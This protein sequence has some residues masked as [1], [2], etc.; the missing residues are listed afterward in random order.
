MSIL[1]L[2]SRVWWLSSST[3]I[4][5]LDNVKWSYKESWYDCRKGLAQKS[6][7][8]HT[9]CCSTSNDV[10]LCSRL[11]CLL[12]HQMCGCWKCCSKRLDLLT[13]PWVWRIK[14]KEECQW[15]CYVL[16]NQKEEKKSMN[17]LLDDRTKWKTW[18]KRNKR[19]LFSLFFIE[20]FIAAIELDPFGADRYVYCLYSFIMTKFYRNQDAIE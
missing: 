19:T 20:S 11:L 1:N 6:K 3:E 13:F 15:I 18:K 14:R 8:F 2:H 17:M 10:L 7:E 9:S 4:L 5:D 16:I 12:R